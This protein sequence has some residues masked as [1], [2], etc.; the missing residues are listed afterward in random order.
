[1][2]KLF[3]TLVLFV[4]LLSFGQQKDDEIKIAISNKDNSK[5]KKEIRSVLNNWHKA[6]ADAEFDNYFSYMTSNSVFI[7]T[8]NKENWQNEEFKTYSKPHFDKGKAWSFK[9]IDRNIYINET[10]DFA[11]F[12]ELLDTQMKICRGSGVLQKVEGEWKIAHYVLSITIPNEK[13]EEAIKLKNTSDSL[14]KE[15]MKQ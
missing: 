7:G 11:W 2:S 15:T 12:D 5:E 13:V 4:S 10:N 9:S 6:A 8:D 14:F 3:L 1:M